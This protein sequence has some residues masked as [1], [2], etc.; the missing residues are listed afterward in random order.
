MC[1]IIA[2]IS[3]ELNIINYLLQ[4]LYKLK[5]RGYDSAGF[6]IIDNNK[7]ITKTF[8]KF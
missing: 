7:Y 6:S 8:I 5:N 3:I 2:M 4:G 1:G